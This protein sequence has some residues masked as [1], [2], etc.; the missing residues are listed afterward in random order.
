[1]RIQSVASI[2]LC[3]ILGIVQEAKAAAPIDTAKASLKSYFKA[4]N[5]PD[6][7]KRT[8]LLEAAWVENGTYTDPGADV[9]GR[10]ALVEH[11][12]QFLSDPQFKGFSIVQASEIDFHHRSFRFRWEMKDPTG[13]AIISGMDYGEFNND[14]AITKIVGFFGPFP[15]LE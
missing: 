4:W 14:G 15:E 11:I 5:E 10:A 1:M 7:K 13:K 9:E 12:G 2:V 8:E 6:A 3:L